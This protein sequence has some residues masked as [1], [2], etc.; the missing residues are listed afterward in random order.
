M[1]V[2]GNSKG[3]GQDSQGKGRGTEENQRD[4]WR[5]VE[6]SDGP[7]KGRGGRRKSEYRKTSNLSRGL[8]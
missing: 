8:N 1:W 5:S 6:G 4:Q 3:R 7:G 2:L